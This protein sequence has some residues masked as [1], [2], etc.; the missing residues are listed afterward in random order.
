MNRQAE[1]VLYYLSFSA[2]VLVDR[3]W[4][5]CRAVYGPRGNDR[6]QIRRGDKQVE[7]LAPGKVN[8]FFEV[9]SRRDDGFHEIETL[10]GADQFVRHI[11]TRG[12][13]VRRGFQ[14]KVGKPSD[15]RMI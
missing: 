10:M 4:M 9:L 14:S 11:D 13:S 3:G 15:L 12:R 5:P 2:L 8:L 7:V 6:V 1:P